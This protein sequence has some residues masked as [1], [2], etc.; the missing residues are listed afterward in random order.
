MRARGDRTGVDGEERVDPGGEETAEQAERGQDH[1]R[2]EEECAGGVG[3]GGRHPFFVE[4]GAP[5]E[6]QTVGHRE[7]RTD[8]QA[9]QDQGLDDTA[10]GVGTEGEFLGDET[11]GGRQSG[12]GGQGHHRDPEGAR[13]GFA[14]PGE[15]A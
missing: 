5:E 6:A 15:F 13:H 14:Q 10:L 3:R 9:E 11:G 1:G 4:E 8:D 7:G 12:H 2:C